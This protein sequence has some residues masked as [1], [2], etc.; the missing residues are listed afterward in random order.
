MK[1]RFLMSHHRKNSVR[2]RV[3]GKKWIYLESN[4]L[5]IESGP[6]QKGRGLERNILYRDVSEGE[7]SLEIWCD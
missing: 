5:Q 6:S 1:L 4:T 7:S 2:D 3:I